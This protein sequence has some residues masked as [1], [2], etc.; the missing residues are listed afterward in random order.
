MKDLTTRLIHLQRKIVA[1]VVFKEL[2]FLLL[3]GKL[4]IY[5]NVSTERQDIK[6]N[7]FIFDFVKV[8]SSKNTVYIKKQD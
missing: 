2:Y 7:F 3:I 8:C 1:I 6:Q 4:T 5:Y